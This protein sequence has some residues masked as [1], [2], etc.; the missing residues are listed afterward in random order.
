MSLLQNAEHAVLR[1]P[2]PDA[3]RLAFADAVAATDPD[4]ARVIRA[5]IDVLKAKRAGVRRRLP[6]EDW[7]PVGRASTRARLEPVFADLFPPGNKA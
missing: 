5:E 6:E 2:W 4:R 1:D 3:P 7:I